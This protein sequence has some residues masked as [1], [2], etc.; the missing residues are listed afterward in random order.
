[1]HHTV[2]ALQC[3]ACSCHVGTSG[4]Q[5]ECSQ[6][7]SLDDDDDELEGIWQAAL[8]GA[9]QSKRPDAVRSADLSALVRCRARVQGLRCCISGGSAAGVLGAHAKPCAVLEC[10]AGSASTRCLGYWCW[11]AG[12]PTSEASMSKA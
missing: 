11:Q 4:Y 12:A 7:C 9:Q 10:T 5:T 6:P 1:M 2:T 3:S 8:E